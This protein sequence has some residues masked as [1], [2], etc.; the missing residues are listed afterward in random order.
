MR[1]IA[2]LD[3]RREFWL[4]CDPPRQVRKLAELV[5]TDQGQCSSAERLA[6]PLI[7]FPVHL[8]ANW[9]VIDDPL[10]WIMQH[11]KGNA[12]RKSSGWESRSFCR[13]RA[14]LLCG[15]REYCGEVDPRVLEALSM[16][17][18]WHR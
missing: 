12:R 13:T 17:P 6:H 1:D 4:G 15:I 16:L 3:V 10:Q 11:R 2:F 7:S 14:G 5:G 9:R 8:D 18:E